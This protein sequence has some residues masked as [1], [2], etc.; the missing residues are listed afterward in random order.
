MKQNNKPQSSPQNWRDFIREQLKTTNTPDH[1]E[2]I[3]PL[4]FNW[5]LY[6]RYLIAKHLTS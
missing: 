2:T 5:A 4:T 1:S 6:G 3:R